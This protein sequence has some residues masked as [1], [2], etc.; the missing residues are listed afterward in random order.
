MGEEPYYID[1]ISDYIEDNVLSEAEKGF[2]QTILYG[3]DVDYNSL[4][5][6]TRRFPMMS[7]SQI[8]ILKE[9]QS[10]KEL[11]EFL[12]KYIENVVSSTILVI[13]H[14]YA[15][16]DKRRKGVKGVDSVGVLFE[17]PKIYENQLITWINNYCSD[18]GYVI[19]PQSASMLAEFLG[20][21]I[22]KVSNEIDKLMILLPSGSTI[23][24]S[25]IEKNIGISK[26]YNIFELQKAIAEKN[27]LKA[28]KI[29]NHF[30]NNLKNNPLVKTISLLFPYFN[31]LLKVH[32]MTDKSKNSII[33][34]TGVSP[35]FADDYVKAINNYNPKKL[36]EIIS[37]L[38][39]YDM[40]SKGVENGTS[41]EAELQRELIFKILH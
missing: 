16:L 41:S 30:N 18:N 12:E 29:I 33:K 27:I 31:K 39:E 22:S 36:V 21:E 5:T 1:K 25:D 15:S 3:K 35:Y 14:K 6:I 32:L 4:M 20:T 28:N 9:A 10:F 19:Q 7:S 23:T 17:S 11:P 2:N 37:L 38:R 26:D 13:C 8:I 34:V 24:P 40:K